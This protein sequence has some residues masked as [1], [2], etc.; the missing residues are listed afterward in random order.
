MVSALIGIGFSLSF[1][2][3]TDRIRHAVSLLNSFVKS[4]REAWLLSMRTM[5]LYLLVR[6]SAIRLRS[7]MFSAPSSK[8]VSA[9]CAPEFAP[10]C[11]AVSIIIMISV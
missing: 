2:L 1:G 4:W 7:Q 11:P 5:R 9:H 10:V 3:A 6:F 8:C